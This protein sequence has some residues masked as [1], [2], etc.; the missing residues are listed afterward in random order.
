MEYIE[1]LG[2]LIG[3]HFLAD[4]PLQG[5]FLARG[6][7]RTAPIEGVPFYH[8][9]AAHSG[10]HGLFVGLITGSFVLAIAETIIHAAI[11]D[12]KCRGVFGYDMDQALH[13]LCKVGWAAAIAMWVLP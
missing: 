11:D 12:A 7:N 5:D 1:T 6:K 10:I 13:A 2:L 9:L 3:A 8:P 4:Y